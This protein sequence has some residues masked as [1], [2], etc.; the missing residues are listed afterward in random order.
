[1]AKLSANFFRRMTLGMGIVSSVLLAYED[2]KITRDEVVAILN[3]LFQGLGMEVNFNGMSV[4]PA[5]DG[6][7]DVHLPKELLDKLS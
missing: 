2:E 3:Q 1:M 5:E 4:M 7:L 6:G